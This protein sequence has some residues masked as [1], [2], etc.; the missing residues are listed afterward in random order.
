MEPMLVYIYAML[1]KNPRYEFGTDVL[2]LFIRSRKDASFKIK[3][4][5]VCMMC[6]IATGLKAC[7]GCKAVRYCGEECQKKDWKQ[8][9]RHVCKELRALSRS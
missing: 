8:G 7:N 4:T 5:T 3:M 2:R 9:H 6:G 1:G